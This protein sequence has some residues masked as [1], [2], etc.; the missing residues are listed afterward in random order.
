MVDLII[1]IG[2]SYKTINQNQC[3]AKCLGGNRWDLV[4]EII[5]AYTMSGY[6]AQGAAD[7]GGGLPVKGMRNER[8]MRRLEWL[9]A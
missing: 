7:S 5:T 8:I 4:I 6:Q 9:R 3:Q 1:K 2:L